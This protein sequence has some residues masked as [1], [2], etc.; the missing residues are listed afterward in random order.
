MTEF[1]AAILLAQMQRLEEQ[2]AAALGERHLPDVEASRDSRH[3]A[4]P[5]ERRRDAGL[6]SSVSVPVQRRRSSTA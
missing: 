1:Q 6:L 5:A 4:A 3:H 2:I